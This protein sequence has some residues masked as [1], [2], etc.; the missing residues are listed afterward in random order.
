MKQTE[1]NISGGSQ[2]IHVH[3]AA[4]PLNGDMALNDQL[5]SFRV[6]ENQKK[7]LSEL[8]QQ[9]GYTSLSAFLKNM[10][11]LGAKV[12]PHINKTI[13]DVINSDGI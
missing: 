12:M 8:C 9:N 3:H 1:F 4:N 10:V 6:T 5:L 13:K 11:F 7:Y 2:T